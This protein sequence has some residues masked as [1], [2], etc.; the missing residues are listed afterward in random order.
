MDFK[1]PD[2]LR[3]ALAHEAAKMIVTEGVRDYQQAK[4]KACERLGN[5]QHG[6]LPSNL[7][8]EYAISSFHKTFSLNHDTI[9]AELRCTA[10]QIMYWLKEFSP[11]LVGPVLEGTANANSPINTHAACDAIETVTEVLQQQ[12]I[13]LKIEERRFKLN[14]N[15]IYLPTLMFDYHDCEI[16]VTIFTLRQQYQYPKSQNRSMQ[17]MS[18]KGLTNL[19]SQINAGLDLAL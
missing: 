17:R 5:S 19:V 15:F 6:S 4:R 2:R 9:L 16:Q 14:Q 18:I 10:L 1:K 12:Y 11:Y 13:N 8:I 3:N 7:E